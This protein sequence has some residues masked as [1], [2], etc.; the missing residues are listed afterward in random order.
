MGKK[1][2]SGLL[3]S[4]INKREI[5]DMVKQFLSARKGES[6]SLR[7]LFSG[8]KLTTHPLKM[9]CVDI[10]NSMIEEQR[11]D[12]NERHHS[13]DGGHLQPHLWRTQLR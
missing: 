6:F 3:K 8:L 9:L 10:V 11:R 4:S 1:N 7:K 13:H 5:T 12:N 2:K